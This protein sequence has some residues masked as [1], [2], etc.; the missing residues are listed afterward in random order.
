MILALWLASMLDRILSQLQT[1]V[2]NK[3]QELEDWPGPICPKIKKKV[4]KF[5]DLANIF[6]VQPAGEGI[7]KVDSQRDF[8]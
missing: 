6:Y 8:S 7:F 3:Q 1:R 4:E 2:Y 5:A